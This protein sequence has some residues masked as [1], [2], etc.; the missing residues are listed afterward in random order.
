[1]DVN[2][3]THVINFSLPMESESYIHRIGRT[4]RAGKSGVA[5]TLVTP[6][7]QYKLRRLEGKTRKSII[8][9]KIP[10][11]EE[12]ME[13]HLDRTIEEFETA[14]KNPNGF[15]RYFDRWKSVA[16]KYTAEDITRG[17]VTLLCR[18]ILEKYEDDKELNAPDNFG[19]RSERS[20]GY[21]EFRGSEN[22]VELS[23]NMGSRDNLQ[24]G[25]LI[26]KICNLAGVD[27]RQIGKVF[28]QEHHTQFKVDPEIAGAVVRKLSGISISGKKVIVEHAD[29]KFKNLK[30]VMDK[31]FSGKPEHHREGRFISGRKTYS[32]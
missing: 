21:R 23:I 30:T 27:G 31:K 26:G 28:I 12:I 18:E 1:L 17:F 13:S 7:E 5:I 3:L 16:K 29:E 32:K 20:G 11:L 19:Q 9:S 24:T 15:D 14:L 22:M 2:D 4:G 25:T 8:K 10:G 6:D